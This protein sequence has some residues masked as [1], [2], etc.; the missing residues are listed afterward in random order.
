MGM[1]GFQRKEPKKTRRP[2]TW[3]GHFRPQNCGQKFYGHEDFLV[4]LF[5]IKL[6][7]LGF[8]LFSQRSPCF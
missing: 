4:N 3:R 6:G 8:P 2:Q 1:G 5:L 7:I